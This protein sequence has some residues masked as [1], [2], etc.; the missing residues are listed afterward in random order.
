[1][2]TCGRQ[3]IGHGVMEIISGFPARGFAHRSSADC[4]RRDIGD[5]AADFMR[6]IRDIGGI[7]S[8]STAALIT[9][10]DTAEWDSG[11]DTGAV[12]DFFI[13]VR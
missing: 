10:S 12:V 5:G 8:D 11:A 13:I 1:M 4:G 2:D 6:G 9:D 7:T 3:V